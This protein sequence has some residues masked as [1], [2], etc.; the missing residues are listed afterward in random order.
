MPL[1]HCASDRLGTVTL[2]LPIPLSETC[3]SILLHRMGTSPP[4]DLKDNNDKFSKAWDPNQPFEILIDQIEEA[5]EHEDAGGQPH[6]PM[7]I[8]NNACTIVFNTGVFF[9]DCKTWR[10]KA[11]AD[12]TWTNFKTHFSEAQRQLRPHP[13]CD[14]A[15]IWMP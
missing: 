3:S 11:E 7:Q 2:D 13:K 8:V 14:D 1:I 9:D 4:I 6:T 15:S 12:K 5:V 10:A